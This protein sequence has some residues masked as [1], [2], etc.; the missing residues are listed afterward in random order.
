MLLRFS[1]DVINLKPRA[2]V[3]LAGVNDI[4][5][6]TGPVTDEMIEG[7]LASMCESAHTN[8]IRVILASILPVISYHGTD[9]FLLV[10]R[11]SFV[12]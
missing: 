8:G 2:V 1:P 10:Q 12:L 3:I 7:N 5:G 11:V 9:P 6:N 4:A